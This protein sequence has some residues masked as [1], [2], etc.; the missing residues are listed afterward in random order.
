MTQSDKELVGAAI[1]ILLTI[2]GLLASP[3]RPV[4]C[5]EICRGFALAAD[6]CALILLAS[7]EN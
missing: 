6:C 3:G 7:P 2:L 4:R 5:V 1:T